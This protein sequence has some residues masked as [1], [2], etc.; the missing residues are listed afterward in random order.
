MINKF[1]L[2]LN[3]EEKYPKSLYSYIDFLFYRKISTFY[4]L[5]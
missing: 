3:F 4:F 5:I 2:I 1:A